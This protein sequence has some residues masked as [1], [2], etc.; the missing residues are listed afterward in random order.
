MSQ[1]TDGSTVLTVTGSLF[2]TQITSMSGHPHV[3]LD[4]CAAL[5]P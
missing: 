5:S 1:A 4:V 3:L 2:V